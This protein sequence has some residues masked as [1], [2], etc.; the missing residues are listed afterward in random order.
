MCLPVVPLD[1]LYPFLQEA[2][3]AV[4]LSKIGISLAASFMFRHRIFCISVLIAY[5]FASI[6]RH[7][8]ALRICM[9][10]VQ[11][12][13]RGGQVP[14]LRNLSEGA[15]RRVK[16]LVPGLR[17]VTSLGHRNWCGGWALT[18]H[19]GTKDTGTS[20]ASFLPP[21]SMMLSWVQPAR[22]FPQRR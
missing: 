21:A 13:L 7:V 2:L 11:M 12:S 5:N 14:G 4:T 1:L 15:Q 8:V 6:Q 17:T 3:L 19:L 18:L 10:R 20:A 22:S 16:Q 9:N